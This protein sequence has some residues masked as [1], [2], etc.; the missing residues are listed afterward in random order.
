MRHGCL[1]VF[2]Y[3]SIAHLLPVDLF[4]LGRIKAKEMLGN[5]RVHADMTRYAAC[6]IGE[7]QQERCTFA[8]PNGF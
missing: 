1:A 4:R 6:Y 7:E 3:S 2:V 8:A 5:V